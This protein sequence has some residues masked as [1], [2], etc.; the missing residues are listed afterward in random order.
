M[1]V[2][3]SLQKAEDSELKPL[4]KDDKKRG[5]S[6]IQAFPSSVSQRV[7][8][9]RMGRGVRRAREQ[10]QLDLELPTFPAYGSL[11]CCLLSL[12]IQGLCDDH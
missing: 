9:P 12:R 6:Q 10:G 5:A 7:Q 8:V 11:S 4:L 3:F 2:V 1:D